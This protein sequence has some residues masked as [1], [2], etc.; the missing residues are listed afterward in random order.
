[1]M[2]AQ[3]SHRTRGGAFAVACLVALACATGAVCAESTSTSAAPTTSTTEPPRPPEESGPDT[4]RGA[5]ARFLDAARQGRYAP[6]AEYLNL[7]DIPRS[8]RAQRGAEYA[9]Q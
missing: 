1:M 2:D 3:R 5:M 7:S 8:Q 9:R 4:P 6:A